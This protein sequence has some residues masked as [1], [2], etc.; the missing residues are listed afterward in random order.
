MAEYGF[1]A[2][3]GGNVVVHKVGGSCNTARFYVR[4][5][6]SEDNLRLQSRDCQV[7]AN[8]ESHVPSSLTTTND[9]NEETCA[10]FSM[11]SSCLGE[12]DEERYKYYVKHEQIYYKV[13]DRGKRKQLLLEYGQADLH[14]RFEYTLRLE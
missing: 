2:I 13:L 14:R 1:W 7:K 12:D 11:I 3:D 8:I 4:M 6:I 5:K 9:Y 10:L